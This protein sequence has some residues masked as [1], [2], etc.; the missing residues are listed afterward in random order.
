[1]SEFD[2]TAVARDVEAYERDGAVV[3][4]DVIPRSWTE[5]MRDMIERFTADPPR[6][7]HVYAA[8][9][10]GVAVEGMFTWLR[11]EACAGFVRLGVLAGLAA[12]AMRSTTVRLFYDQ[13]FVREP[14]GSAAGLATPLH[15]DLPYWPVRGDQ[16]VSI[17]VP[18]DPVDR[19]SGVVQ[20]IR[21]SH[22]WSTVYRPAGLAALAVADGGYG[23]GL[24]TAELDDPERLIRENDVL[25][26]D[27]APG[28]VLLHHPMTLHF[29]RANATTD[30]R[31]RAL[32]VRYLGDDAVWADRQGTFLHL[33]PVR[34]ELPEFDLRDGEPFHHP[35]FPVV[36]PPR[37]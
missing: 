18:F 21:G 15:Q 7:V 4:R 11:D 19:R 31:R 24:R 25:A 8:Q 17:W 23:G 29:A 2:M 5:T 27:M 16:V 26:W 35:L 14:G 1:V 30:V 32:S 28:D 22:R 34:A 37:D 36:W 6:M 12:A 9:G 3:V 20:Y 33:P 13:L 10:R